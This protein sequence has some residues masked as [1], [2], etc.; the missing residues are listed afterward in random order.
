MA[1][2][3]P[4]LPSFVYLGTSDYALRILREILAAKT[5]RLR[6]LIGSGLDDARRHAIAAALSQEVDVAAIRDSSAL[7]DPAFLTELRSDPPDFA[8]SAHFSE[9][10]AEAHGKFADGLTRTLDR[11]NSDFHSK[12]SGAVGLLSS[13]IEE[14]EVTVSTAGAPRR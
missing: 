13:A 4:P 12:L 14:L 10:L 9:I 1:A 3:P 7:R 11:A 5:S 2:P 6:Y 8:L